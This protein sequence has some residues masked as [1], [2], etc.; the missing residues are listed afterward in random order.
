M[1]NRFFT[2][3]LMSF[4]FILPACCVFK[5]KCSNKSISCQIEQE[6]VVNKSESIKEIETES[7]K[8]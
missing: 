2:I 7:V 5:K 3:V 1:Y 6:E 8:F 4:I